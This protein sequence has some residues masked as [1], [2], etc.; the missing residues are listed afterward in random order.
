MQQSHEEGLVKIYVKKIQALAEQALDGADV[1]ENIRA[2][3]VE[4]CTHFDAVVTSSPE[5]NRAAFKGRLSIYGD[6]VHE[7]Q[8]KYR[9][10]LKYAASLVD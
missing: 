10:M 3:V 5:Q 4:A 6:L 9:E 7:S 8:P 2:V 1:R